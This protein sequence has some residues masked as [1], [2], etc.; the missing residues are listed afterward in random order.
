MRLTVFMDAGKLGL[1]N[2]VYDLFCI[3]I[4]RAVDLVKYCTTLGEHLVSFHLGEY[5][6]IAIFDIPSFTSHLQSVH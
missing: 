4:W 1:F 6:Y 2:K 5:Q 3:N